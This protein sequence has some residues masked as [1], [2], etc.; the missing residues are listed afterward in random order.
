M[1]A[2]PRTEKPQSS[3]FGG[4]VHPA[5]RS[6]GRVRNVPSVIFRSPQAGVPLYRQDVIRP[7]I[8]A[9]D[10]P[11]SVSAFAPFSYAIF[12]YHATGYARMGS[13]APAPGHPGMLAAAGILPADRGP[14]VMDGADI[15]VR[16]RG[17]GQPGTRLGKIVGPRR[18][19]DA[20]GSHLPMLSDDTHP[21]EDIASLPDPAS[22]D[23]HPRCTRH[24]NSMSGSSGRIGC[25]QKPAMPVSIQMPGH[26]IRFRS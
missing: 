19:P 2:G 8:W 23:N 18:H 22:V 20:A 24:G 9:S 7:G 5:R 11:D 10:S 3:S 4:T 17:T 12:E 13:N 26:R 25:R 6:G 1:W 16:N 14:D 21:I 15:A